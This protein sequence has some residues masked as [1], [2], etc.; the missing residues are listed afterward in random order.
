MSIKI[1]WRLAS[2]STPNRRHEIAQIR[3]P[4]GVGNSSVASIGPVVIPHINTSKCYHVCAVSAVNVPWMNISMTPKSR[5]A[6]PRLLVVPNQGYVFLPCT[7]ITAA[8]RD[9]A[10]EVIVPIS[11]DIPIKV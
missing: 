5:I 3:N 11:T 1:Y 9:C 8:F 2:E 4:D 10:R 7:A 6:P